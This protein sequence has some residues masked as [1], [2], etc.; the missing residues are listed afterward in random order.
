MG[1]LRI[2]SEEDIEKLDLKTGQKAK[3]RSLR[4]K[5]ETPTAEGRYDSRKALKGQRSLPKEDTEPRFVKCSRDVV[6]GKVSSV[7]SATGIHVTKN[8][9]G[10][11]QVSSSSGEFINA[12]SLPHHEVNV[13][14][15]VRFND[16][17]VSLHGITD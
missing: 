14:C 15:F 4:R 2:L 5:G 9:T 16:I 6:P 7:K 1:T 17:Y 12:Y 8:F 3:I 11:A 10:F 13:L